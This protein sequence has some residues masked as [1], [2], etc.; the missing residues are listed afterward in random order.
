MILA[1]EEANEKRGWDAGD[2][3]RN[4]LGWDCNERWVPRATIQP[5]ESGFLPLD[6]CVPGPSLSHPNFIPDT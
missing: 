4:H 3:G 6:F 2:G 1:I 5:Q